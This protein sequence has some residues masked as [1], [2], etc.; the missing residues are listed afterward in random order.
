MNQVFKHI[1]GRLLLDVPAVADREGRACVEI[2]RHADE[3]F[4]KPCEEGVISEG[5]RDGRKG[6]RTAGVTRVG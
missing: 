5:S 6:G 1:L 4:A 2:L 3:K